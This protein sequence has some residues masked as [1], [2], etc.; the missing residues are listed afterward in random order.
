MCPAHP[1]QRVGP[2][3][4]NVLSTST[5]ISHNATEQDVPC[6]PTVKSSEPEVRRS[7]L[8]HYVNIWNAQGMPYSILLQCAVREVECGRV[9]L[10]A[11]PGSTP[12]SYG[13]YCRDC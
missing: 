12:N 10:D 5:P 7:P 8:N 6:N 2:V 11:G 1:Q 9:D 13:E 4:V 3:R